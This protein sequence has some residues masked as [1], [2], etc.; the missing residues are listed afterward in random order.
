MEH[1]AQ[2]SAKEGLGERKLR[3]VI[4]WTEKPLHPAA[5]IF[6]LRAV[7]MHYFLL[8]IPQLQ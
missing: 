5:I 6:L 3:T 8:T 4:G 1:E 2:S 7:K